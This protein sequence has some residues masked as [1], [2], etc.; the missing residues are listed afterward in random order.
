MCLATALAILPLRIKFYDLFLIT[1]IALAILA[2]VGCWYHLVPHF[3]YAYGYQ[4]WL[5]IAFA[6]WSADRLAR[7]ARVA[8]YN[9]LGNSTAIVEVIPDCNIMQITVFPRVAWNFGPGQHTFLYFPSLGKFWE[10]HPFS[11]AGWKRRG[12][13]T[14][15]ASAFI[16]DSESNMKEESGKGFGV[17]TAVPGLYSEPN[18][19]AK[20]QQAVLPHQSHIQDC[21]SIQFLTRV[22]SGMT[23]TLHRRLSSSLSRSRIETSVYIEGPYAGH[24]A[25]LQPLLVADTVLC[26]VGGI[27]ITNILGFLQEYSSANLSSGENP[28]KSRG[29]MK[30]A[31]RFILAWSAKEIALIEHVKRNFLIQT[32]NQNGIE[33]SFWCTHPSY[34][35]TQKSLPLTT[36]TTKTNQNQPPAFTS[37]KL[38]EAVPTP[39][40]MEISAV[41]RSSLEVGRHTTVLVCG[42]GGMADEATREVVRCVKDGFRVDLVEEAFAW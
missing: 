28:T 40:R 14:F 5:F 22:H 23:S 19:L 34:T 1:H 2:L 11:I 10:S 3:G 37:T 17:A 12:Q 9:R 6:F 16:S 18:S 27:G 29:I 31:K 8:Y 7:L 35:N 21:T 24:R 41:L 39:G 25:T 33:Y 15:G 4:V 42:P 13:S 36:T 38:S 26:L 30:Q 20:K 32:D